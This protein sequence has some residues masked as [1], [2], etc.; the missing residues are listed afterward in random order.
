[1]RRRLCTFGKVFTDANGLNPT[2]AITTSQ[3]SL[4]VSILS[5]GTV[6]GALAA[7]PIADMTGR[8]MGIIISCLVFSIGVAF[9][10][11]LSPPA[12]PARFL[13]HGRT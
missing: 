8:K 11:R 7:A 6:F 5:V 9:Q 1:M 13:T 4:V 3:K 12:R 2:C 10:V